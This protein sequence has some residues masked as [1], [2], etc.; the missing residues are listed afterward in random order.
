MANLRRG[1]DEGAAQA[2]FAPPLPPGVEERALCEEPFLFVRSIQQIALAAIV[3]PD[4]EAHYRR[5]FRWY[6]KTFAT[7]LHEVA[8]LPLYDVLLAYY[9]DRYELLDEKEREAV[10]VVLAETQSE[11]S[12]RLA[13]KD[14]DAQADDEWVAQIEAEEAERLAAMES[15]A[16]QAPEL[17]TF[18]K[19][20]G[21]A[22]LRGL[23]PDP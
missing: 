15:A 5:I 6:S 11:R 14:K 4:A 22:S 13:A 3:A 19:T 16:A 10:R 21:G 20:Y 17:P 9:E 23:T 18:S 12:E 1:R 2:L 8:A 7:P